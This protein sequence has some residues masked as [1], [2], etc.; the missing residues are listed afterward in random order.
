MAKIGLKTLVAELLDAKDSGSHEFR[1]LYNIGVRGI[2]EFNT[3]V[4][5]TFVTKLLDVNANKTVTL[6]D[7]FISFSK[8]GVIN[9]KGEIVTLRLNNQL[10]NFNDAH[11]TKEARFDGV[12]RL[13]TVTNPSIPYSYPYIYYNFF[14][15]FYCIIMMVII[16]KYFIFFYYTP[17]H[18]FNIFF[19]ASTN[20][21]II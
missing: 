21:P 13:T 6:P 11:I 10:S 9:E 4:V 8:A 19:L 15:V 18:F 20:I 17:I 12:P 16:T 2:R 3:D 14:I 7:D 1:R 5:G